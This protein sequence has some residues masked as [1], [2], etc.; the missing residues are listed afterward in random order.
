M[1]TPASNHRARILNLAGAATIATTY[2]WA[3]LTAA[4]HLNYTDYNSGTASAAS[5]IS[6]PLTAGYLFGAILILAANINRIPLTALTLIPFAAALN[7]TAG[8]ITGS[9]GI[10]LYLDSIATVALGFLYGPAV[11]AMTGI[12]TSLIWGLTINPTTIP[13]AAGSAAIGLL[14]G[15]VSRYGLTKKLWALLPTGFTTGILAGLLGAPVA[16]FVYGGGQGLGTGT[17]V[18]TLQATGQT[19]LQATTLQSLISDPLDK[20]ITFLIAWIIIRSIPQRA[21]KNHNPA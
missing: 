9:T 1:T 19:L 7:I 18:A 5:V 2:I 15:L 8:Q 10:P 3:M 11:G 17:L 20:T 14:A 12:T 13:F 4:G 21:L 6:M 16:A